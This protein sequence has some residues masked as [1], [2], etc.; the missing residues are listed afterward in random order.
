MP[1]FSVI[2]QNSEV[3]SLVQDGFLERAFHDALYPG[4]LF[5]A[6]AEP[7]F[8][9]AQVG[10]RQIFTGR[11]LMR[12]D[13]RPLQPGVDATVGTYG[14]EQWE[15]TAQQWAKSID[16]PM[17]TSINAIANLFLGDAHTL[18]LQAAATMNALVRNTAYNAA[19]SG[20]T[21]VTAPVT[22]ATI[23]VARLNGFT[24]A[25]RP[26]LPAGS[27]VQFAPV[28]ASNPLP[29]TVEESGVAAA[30]TVIAFTPA[31]AGDEVGPGTLTLNASVAVIARDAVYA[32][33]RSVVVRSG[34]G[35]KVDALD[36]SDV[37]TLAVV[38]EALARLQD[39]N[40]PTMADGDYYCHLPAI[41]QSQIFS[42]LEFQ[43]LNQSLP[44]YIMYKEFTV[45]RLLGTNF[46]RNSECPKIDTVGDGVSIG[47][48]VADN[49]AGELTD[50][51]AS[52]GIR[53]QRPIIFGGGAVKEYYQDL[54]QLLTDAGV[55]GR[56]VQPQ[57]TNNGIEIN[58]ERIQLYIRGPL[59]RL[60]QN[61][62][63]TWNFIGGFVH[64]TDA[65]TGDAAAFK[66]TIVIEHAS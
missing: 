36:A 13:L 26:D 39:Q 29:I 1:D 65:A 60:G 53:V 11:G 10:D 59:D 3:R 35:T 9:A 40:V 61:V 48:Q 50:S 63:T 7:E 37:M 33:N 12:K 14:K 8:W 42:D 57:I 22:S 24:K 46:L 55:P 49:F 23:T 5:R 51:G 28:S 54:S 38:R 17:P 18:G 34:G 64:R 6:M 44:D 66:R 30:R 58:V 52:T 2:T 31:V 56:V 43:R 19:L 16:T 20:N 4:L 15:V 27:P 45:G 47:Y 25:R 41:S 62:S 21:V 32:D